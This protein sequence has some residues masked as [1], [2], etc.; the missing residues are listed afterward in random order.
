MRQAT[1]EVACGLAG[2]NDAYRIAERKEDDQGSSPAG[3]T[4]S[5]KVKR[6]ERW[7]HPVYRFRQGPGETSRKVNRDSTN[8]ED[9]MAKTA[10][11]VLAGTDSH[12]DL[13]RVFNAIET[14]RE[15]KEEGE[16]VQIIFDGA[17]TEWIPKLEDPEHDA[18]G[19]YA[20]VKDVITGA[21][22][23]CA[24]SF[25]V[26]DQIEETDVELLSEFEGHPSIK[27][28]VDEGY[29]VITF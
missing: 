11:I 10:L 24:K 3:S 16:E 9:T 25:G 29:Q 26:Y 5:S 12:A 21:C 27:S 28:L 7:A 17:G 18:H 1:V 4:Q 8:G 20:S 2:L 19:P 15:Y 23:F 14:A 13:G 6:S 22:Q